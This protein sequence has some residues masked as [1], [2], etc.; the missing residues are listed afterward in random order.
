MEG[1]DGVD[2][3]WLYVAALLS[4]V[5][6][7]TIDLAL[8]QPRHW[9]TFHVI[10]EMLMVAGALLMATAL[11]LGWWRASRSVEAMRS[12]LEQRAAE[13]DAWQ[14]NAEKALEGMAA[15]IDEQFRQW[16][17]TPAERE[18]ALLLLKGRSH[19]A[20]AKTTGR[21]DRTVRQHAASVYHK[22]ALAGRAEL[23]AYFLEGLIL[24]DETGA[25]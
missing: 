23:A 7:G 11:W 22:A 16:Q 5:V 19:K 9:L 1:R 12:L 3:R 8:D 25:N 21:S 20:I 6:G 10:F 4:I 17:L 15:A 14:R 24:P 13:R 18:V 2:L